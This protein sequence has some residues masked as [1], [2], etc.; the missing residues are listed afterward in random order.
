MRLYSIIQVAYRIKRNSVRE[1]KPLPGITQ[2]VTPTDVSSLPLHLT[3]EIL[4][5]SEKWS[6]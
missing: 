6:R 5:M 1:N 2:L 4:A 3:V